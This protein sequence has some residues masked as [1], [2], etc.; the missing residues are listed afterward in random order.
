M[1]IDFTHADTSEE[2]EEYHDRFWGSREVALSD[3]DIEAL[4]AGKA[5][6]VDDGEFSWCIRYDPNA[7]E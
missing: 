2:I 7:D 5:L 3:D 6:L 4:R 1:A